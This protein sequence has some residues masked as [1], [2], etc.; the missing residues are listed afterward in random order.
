MPLRM[1]HM[2]RALVTLGTGSHAE[3]LEIAIPSFEA[4]A[5]LHGYEIVT[6][7]LQSDRPAS[8]WKVPALKAALGVYEAALWVDADVVITDPSQDVPC[9]SGA[10]QA[11]VLHHT[12]DGAVPSCAVWYVTRAML[13][14]LDEVWGMTHRIDHGW[15]EQAALMD[16][17]GFQHHFRPAYLSSPTRLFERTHWIDHG[18]N[19]HLWDAPGPEHPRFMHATMHPDRVAVMRDWAAG[20]LPPVPATACRHMYE[21]PGCPYCHGHFGRAAA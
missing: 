19:T 21:I 6:P 17:M 3:L 16:L 8:W 5:D 14:V 7:E 9:P 1:S 20:K 10:W 12:G 13:P 4:F 2:T 11:L 15:W 18:F